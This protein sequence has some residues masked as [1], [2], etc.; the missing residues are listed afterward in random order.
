MTRL[1]RRTIAKAGRAL[2]SGSS[3]S[4]DSRREASG[5][6]ETRVTRASTVAFA[7]FSPLIPAR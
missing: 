6:K 4:P 1:A 7:F 5:G 3:R 2:V